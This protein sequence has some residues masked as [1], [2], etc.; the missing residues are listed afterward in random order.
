MHTMRPSLRWSLLLPLLLPACVENTAKEGEPCQ[1]GGPDQLVGIIDC[2]RDLE[3][4]FPAYDNGSG[5]GICTRVAEPE[6]HD[7]GH[8]GDGQCPAADTGDSGDSG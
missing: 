6:A 5:G 1:A 7:V 2:E 3:C 8:A 4:C